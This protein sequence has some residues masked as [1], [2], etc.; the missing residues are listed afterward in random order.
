VTLNWGLT[1]GIEREAYEPWFAGQ[2][3]RVRVGDAG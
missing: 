3:R 1:A 2:G